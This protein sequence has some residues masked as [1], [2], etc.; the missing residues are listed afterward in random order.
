MRSGGLQYE[1]PRL[2]L[3]LERV[4]LVEERR[5][6]DDDPRAEVSDALVVDQTWSYQ[7]STSEREL[8]TYR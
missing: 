7:L 6:V 5:N 3:A 1:S 8:G 2:T 4:Q